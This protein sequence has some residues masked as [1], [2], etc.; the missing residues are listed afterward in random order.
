MKHSYLGSNH[1]DILDNIAVVDHIVDFVEAV[2]DCIE[3]VAAD[4]WV[5]ADCR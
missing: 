5:V 1:N 4:S 3:V 2:A